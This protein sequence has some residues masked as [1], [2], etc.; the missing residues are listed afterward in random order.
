MTD[1]G[2]E[3]AVCKTCE[4]RGRVPARYGPEPNDV[5]WE[6]CPNCEGG[7]IDA[8]ETARR[9]Y[10]TTLGY[11]PNFEDT[12]IG[13]QPNQEAHAAWE[14]VVAAIRAQAEAHVQADVSAA[15]AAV[16][17][18]IVHQSFP[19]SCSS[20]G[21]C[22]CGAEL[23]LDNFAAAAEASTTAL[24]SALEPLKSLLLDGLPRANRVAHYQPDAP[25]S[26]GRLTYAQAEALRAA[27]EPFQKT[28]VADTEPPPEGRT[29][30]DDWQ[31]SHRI[32]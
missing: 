20:D 10:M 17:R 24:V 18:F 29:F 5:D 19:A 3:A 8:I 1:S 4:G 15:R 13:W 28:Q 11:N 27:L 21:E 32:S 6:A 26:L 16:E 25:I 9:A 30:R 2:D 22:V 7:R 23:A 12:P 31:R 14:G